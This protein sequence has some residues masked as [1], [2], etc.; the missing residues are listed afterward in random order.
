MFGGWDH[1]AAETRG[2]KWAHVQ[3]VSL[4]LMTLLVG[5]HFV[6]GVVALFV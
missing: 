6:K 4:L 3:I 1:C 5:T 2:L